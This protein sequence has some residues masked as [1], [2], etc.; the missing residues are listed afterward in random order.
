MALAAPGLTP[1]QEVYK[2][3]DGQGKVVYSD[4][5]VTKNAPKTSLHV[6]PGNPAEAAAGRR[7]QSRLL[8]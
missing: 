5:G 6:E 2:S 7:G 1:A 4:R 8:P 3:V